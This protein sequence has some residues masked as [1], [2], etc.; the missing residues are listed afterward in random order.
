MRSHDIVLFGATGFT[1]KLVAEY[2]VK[3]RG[4]ARVALA[5]RDRRKLE[6]LSA[7]LGGGLPLVIA[8]AADPA[9]L[10]EVARA[11]RV[12]CTTVGP[13]AKY[14]S[15]L[16]A[17]CVAAGTDYCDLTGEPQWVRRM[18]DAH[19]EEAGR[20]GAR[21]VHCAG[22][23]S[24]PS[25]L[26][27]HVLQA[28]A[29][30]TFGVPCQAITLG[31]RK[32]KGGASGGTIASMLEVLDEAKRD[33]EVRRGLTDA[34]S[35]C[36]GEPRGP[37]SGRPAGV[38]R[39]ADLGALTGPFVMGAIN[40][41]VVRRTNALS[42]YAYGRD[43]S[44]RELMCFPDGARGMAM[45]VGATAGLAA[46]VVAASAG[47][48][49]KLIQGKLPAPGEG[50]SAEARERGSFELELVG[51]GVGRDGKPFRTSLRVAAKG[52]PGY[53]VTSRMLGETA[54][55]LATD[56]RT[57]GGGVLTPAIALGDALVRRL[58]A[59][60]MVLEVIPA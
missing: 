18:I 58:R 24:I 3:N 54:L 17:A 21:I 56:E 8:D 16:V 39:N 37:D 46:A 14:G 60:G 35:L 9:S 19:H 43:F 5:G 55:C 23:D 11:T 53:L 38:S 6:A 41:R 15:A 31:V 40:E 30:A 27:V 51:R 57:S 13:Y 48:I 12:V 45:A 4:G 22:F 26:G 28:H 42:G 52:D 25:D 33:P 47:P 29:K 20:T 7:E 1:G 44:Y 10:A 49:R 59:M 32:L 50:P 2:L 36:P 34:Y